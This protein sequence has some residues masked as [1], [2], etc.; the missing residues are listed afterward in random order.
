[1]PDALCAEFHAKG[2]YTLLAPLWVQN[3]PAAD[4]PAVP[5]VGVDLAVTWRSRVLRNGSMK[6][7]SRRQLAVTWRSRV[8]RNIPQFD[9]TV[10][11][12]QLP[13]DQGCSATDPLKR[14]S[15][16]QLPDNQGCS[17]TTEVSGLNAAPCSYLTIK[18]APQPVLL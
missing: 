12:L 11:F 4:Q 5:R 2:V 9:K 6:S 18:G 7:T 8:L 13:G 17:A 3:K 1:M 15:F 16:L 10:G 14:A